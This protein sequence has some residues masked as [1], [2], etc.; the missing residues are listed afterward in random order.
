MSKKVA[1]LDKQIKVLGVAT[2]AK[3]NMANWINGI[4][5]NGGVP[6]PIGLGE[7]WGGWLWRTKQ[8]KNALNK[9]KESEIVLITDVYDA[10]AIRDLSEAVKE[11]KQMKTRILVSVEEYWAPMGLERL[12]SS[13][14]EESY[15]DELNN[16]FGKSFCQTYRQ[17]AI[18]AGQIIGYVKDL[19]KLFQKNVNFMSA[20][21]NDDQAA[22]YYMYL[23]YLR[24]QV[25]N[26]PFK[27]DFEMKVFS[28]LSNDHQFRRDW[29]WHDGKGWY[30]TD[31]QVYP[32]CLH[33]A[34]E[35][36]FEVYRKMGQ[37]VYGPLFNT[38]CKKSGK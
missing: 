7:P 1:K 11:F 8:V 16:K 30:H 29:E 6:V 12:D 20:H 9:L 15:K 26:A 4:V 13:F 31:L 23:P 14:T 22:L 17:R 28:S 32:P 19:R 10:Y 24:G 2:H 33:F 21:I 34:G 38:N 5:L 25:K 35:G 37:R 18:N 3:W 36:N 27:L